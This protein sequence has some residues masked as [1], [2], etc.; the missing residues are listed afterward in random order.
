[1]NFQKIQRYFLTTTQKLKSDIEMDATHIKKIMESIRTSMKDEA[2]SLKNL[3]DEVASE[4][5]EHT[6][7]MEK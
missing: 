4:N 1:M 5:I 3:V 6:H 7:T 2:K